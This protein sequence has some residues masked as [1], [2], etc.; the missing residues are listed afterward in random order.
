MYRLTAFFD[1]L[2]IERNPFPPFLAIGSAATFGQVDLAATIAG[3]GFW[4]HQPT[5]AHVLA[6]WDPVRRGMR[7]HENLRRFPVILDY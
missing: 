7:Q 3:A 2:P 1:A 4:R 6:K 5:L